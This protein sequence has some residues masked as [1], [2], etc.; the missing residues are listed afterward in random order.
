M[1]KRTLTILLIIPFIISLLTFVSIQILDNQVASDILGI[2]WNYKENE[3]FQIDPDN[4]YELEAEPIIDPNLIL[5]NGNDLI[6]YSKKENEADPDCVSI[7]QKN[8]KFFLYALEEGEVEIYCSNERK[9]VSRHF[10]A[11]IFEDGAMV[12]NP[13]RKGS[14][15]SVTG[16]KVYGLY[17]LAYSDVRQGASY[18]KNKSTIQIETTSFSEEGTSE[19]NRLIECSDNVSYRDNTITLLGAGES[20]VTLEEPDYNFRAT[21]KFTVVDGVNIYSYDDLLMATNYSSSGESIVLQTNLESLKN[22][23]TPKMQGD[24]VIGYTQEKL[25]SAKDNTELFGHYNFQNDTFSFNEELYLFD[26]TYDSTYIDFYNNLEKNISANKSIS[27]KV[28]AGIHIRNDVYGNGFTINMNNLCFPNHGEYSLD[29]KGK[30]TPNKELDYFFGPLPFIS[31]GDYLELPLIVALGQDNCGVYVDRDGVT[32]SDINLANSNN[33]NNLYDLTYTGSVIDVKAKDVTIE[34]STIEKGKVC[35]RA[36]DADN[37]LLDNCILKNAGEFTLLVG[38]DK[39]NSYDTS[40][41]VTETLEDGTQVNRDFT[42][43]FAPDTSTP[44]TADSRLTK[45]LQATM[46]GNVGAKD[47]NGNLLYDY[48]KEL[49]TIQKYLDNKN[50]IETAAS[51]RVKDCLFGRS[52]VF[53]IAS[54][55]LFNGPLLYGEIPS[56]ITSLLSMLGELPT[57][58]GGTSYPV[59]L[60]I[61]GDTR[62]YDWKSID[63]IDVSSLIE[64][65]I[66]ATLNSIG[67]GDKEVSIDDIFPMKGSLRKEASQKGF[68][69]TENGTQYLNTV[70]AYYGGGLNLSVMNPGEDSSYNTYSD[71]YEVDLV[72]EI[73]NS[74]DSGMSALM[75][76]AVVITIGTHPFRFVTNSKKESSTTLLSVD[77]APKF[78][79][80]KDHYNRR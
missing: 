9:T 59:N 18:S 31:V 22:V 75:I 25:P 5:A 36:Y 28:K 32:I 11:T 63:S 78:E 3:G 47:E 6:W 37:L 49:N 34:H 52:G 42:S 33:F 41:Q 45:F 58:I 65:N 66:S 24:K 44:D 72:D 17:D 43:F 62:F 74:T 76:D 48:K 40:R 29:G 26:T 21:Y 14:G 39:K 80:L 51:I 56:M 19:K 69:H 53:S 7:E 61:E 50:N 57:R 46:D 64:E 77:S 23:Y 67:F 30:L 8:D 20:F 16:K 68:I 60:T 73:I 10:K 71:E 12:I 2:Q 54:E 27:K 35:V 55:S 79:D 4:G 38:S 1:K 15:K 13:M 70:L